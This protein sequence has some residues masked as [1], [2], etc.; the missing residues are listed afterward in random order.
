MVATS[1]SVQGVADRVS[2]AVPREDEPGAFAS[3]LIGLLGDRAKRAELGRAAIE[4]ARADFAAEACYGALPAHLF[5]DTLSYNSAPVGSISRVK[6][7]LRA[8]VDA[9]S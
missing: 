7:D 2:G 3:A 4:I 5:P 9:H 1:V 8:S 6:P